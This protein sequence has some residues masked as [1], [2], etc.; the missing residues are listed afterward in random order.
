MRLSATFLLT[1]TLAVTATAQV[2]DH[3]MQVY[4]AAYVI[5]THN[6]LPSKMADDSVNPDVRHPADMKVQS[7]LP[8]ASWRAGSP[9]CSSPTS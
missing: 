1:A 7:D 5:D 2:G 3:A 9:P 4:R 8:R 6:D